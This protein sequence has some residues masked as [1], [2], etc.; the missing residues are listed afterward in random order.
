VIYKHNHVFRN[1]PGQ[2]I[3][4]VLPRLIFAKVEREL[5]VDFK[6]FF[7][8]SY[9]KFTIFHII[10]LVWNQFCL[11]L[12]LR[13]SFDSLTFL[14]ICSRLVIEALSKLN[15]EVFRKKCNS[16]SD[17]LHYALFTFTVAAFRISGG[18]LGYFMHTLLISTRCVL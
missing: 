3:S 2:D 18:Y 6:S 5:I 15:E 16:A 8:L 14:V 1:T 11:N 17:K 13:L 7:K 12:L 9:T 10:I 4:P